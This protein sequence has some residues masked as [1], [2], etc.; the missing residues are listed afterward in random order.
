[1]QKYLRIIFSLVLLVYLVVAV[2]LSNA[3]EDNDLCRGVNISVEGSG[4]GRQ[5]V[6]AEELAHEINDLPDKAAKMP[7]AN[8]NTQELRKTLLALDKVEDAQVVRMTDGTLRITAQPIV[9]VARIFD[10]GKSYY[11][12]KVGKRVT[13]NARYHQDVPVIAGH[14]DPADTA[15]TPQ[16]L[17]PLIEYISNDSVWNSFISMIKVQSP[18]DIILVP[19]IKEHVINIGAPDHFDDKFSRLRKFYTVVLPKQGWEKYDTLTLKWRGQL[20]ASKRKRRA[21]HVET[22][23]YDDDEAVDTGTMLAG[24]N[25]AP[26]QTRPGVKANSDS[27]IPKRQ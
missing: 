8:I 15:F 22:I 10:N 21:Q 11:I 16:S 13:A 3:Q 12:N 27:P 9:P 17:L 23:Q 5:F 14:F 24:F 18:N 4:P 20:V 6:T 7:L 19:N 25:V 1:M 2:T 26:G